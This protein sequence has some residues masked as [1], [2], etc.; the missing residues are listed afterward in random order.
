MAAPH[1]PFNAA[2]TTTPASTSVQS[3]ESKTARRRS[4]TDSARPGDV[5]G[6][7]L[8]GTLPPLRPP[9]RMIT[10]ATPSALGGRC[11]RIPMLV[12]TRAQA[13]PVISPLENPRHDHTHLVAE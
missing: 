4:D 7:S 12:T 6:S 5:G 3:T 9:P 8:S 10:Q 1:G 11:Q 2:H 13:H